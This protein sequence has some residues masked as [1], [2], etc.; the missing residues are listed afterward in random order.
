MIRPGKI[1]GF[2]SIFLIPTWKVTNEKSVWLRK[3]VISTL[4]N[5]KSNQFLCAVFFFSFL[6]K[7]SL[8]GDLCRLDAEKVARNL[9]TV[10]PFQFEFVPVSAAFHNLPYSRITLAIS[11]HFSVRSFFKIWTACDKWK[12]FECPFSVFKQHTFR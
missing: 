2:C 1:R 10:C 11:Q 9:P 6:T 3:N 12:D 8:Q 7:C 4:M 5:F